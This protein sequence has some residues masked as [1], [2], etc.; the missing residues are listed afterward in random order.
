MTVWSMAWRIDEP[1]VRGQIDNR[2]RGRLTGRIWFLGRAE[3]VELDL[4]GN[5][6]RDV[7]G[8]LLRFEN[9]NPTEMDLSEL[10]VE[11]T[12]V[13]G[14]VTAS[15]KVKVPEISPEEMREYY[16][17]K[18]PFP[19]HWGNSLYLEWY[20][21]QNGRVVIESAD[22]VLT[23]EGEAS[24]EMS[25]AEEYA[26]RGSNAEAM[27]G[28]MNRLTK[29]VATDEE[30]TDEVESPPWEAERIPTEAEAEAWQARQDIL[31]DRVQARLALEGRAA[32][33]E[34]IL[35]EERERQRIEFGEPPPPPD[36]ETE[37]PSLAELS[38]AADEAW[39]LN[40][41]PDLEARLDRTHPLVET[42]HDLWERLH[43][44]A[45]EHGWVPAD[46]QEEHPVVAM[47]TSTMCVGPKLAGALNGDSW[48]PELEFCA[49]AIVRLKRARGYLDDALLAAE[50]CQEDDLIPLI[51][52]G[53]LTV[54][55]VDLAHEIDLL[56]AELRRRLD[57]AGAG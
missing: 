26:Q 1:V 4:Q 20:S 24:W 15:R 53:P 9:P 39:R 37:G 55:L 19:W 34:K 41:D 36:L 21:Q 56:I 47:I 18:K 35:D 5:A 6:W 46:A 17:A 42:S 22:Y 7:A 57:E 32:D 12:G 28:F 10:R 29:G 13:I 43:Y 45:N 23:L 11:Q 49:S 16:R 51:H 25:E 31:L 44:L 14:D 30:D 2:Q 48:P 50:S 33:F 40:P 27:T 52:L 8:R 54:D 38:A 3:P